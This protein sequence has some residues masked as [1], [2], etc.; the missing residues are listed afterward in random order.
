MNLGDIVAFI[1]YVIHEVRLFFAILGNIQGYLNAYPF[2]RVLF[3]LLE[4][5]FVTVGVVMVLT[6]SAAGVRRA[7]FQ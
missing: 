3:E 2:D 5:G 6:V 4:A 7:I 1:A